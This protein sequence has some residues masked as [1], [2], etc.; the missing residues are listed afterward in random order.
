MG[1]IKFGINLPEDLVDKFDNEVNP[2]FV[3][4][5][6]VVDYSYKVKKQL[7]VVPCDFYPYNSKSAPQNKIWYA[8]T[9][10]IDTYYEYFQG[11]WDS[12]AENSNRIMIDIIRCNKKNDI[13]KEVKCAEEKELASILKH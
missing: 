2:Y 3:Y 10:C 8:K 13:F 5:A 4:R 1:D 12:A 9:F 7:K 6:K 11:G